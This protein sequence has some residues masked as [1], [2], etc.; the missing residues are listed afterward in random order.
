[1]TYR[2]PECVSHLETIGIRRADACRLRRIAMVLQNWHEKLCGVRS[3]HIE[4]DEV[5]G[6]PRWYNGITEE[7]YPAKDTETPALA[8][9]DKI[10]ARYPDMRHYVQTDPRGASLYIIPP[11]VRARCYDMPLRAFYSEGVAVYK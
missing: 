2:I 4:R 1:M 10:M 9:L 7:S 8:R 11:E 3:G 5:T 6:K